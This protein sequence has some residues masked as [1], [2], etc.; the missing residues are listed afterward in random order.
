MGGAAGKRPC[1]K[2]P[3]MEFYLTAASARALTNA[4]E[5]LVRKWDTLARSLSLS[6]G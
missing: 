4:E 6:F 5:S 1:C 2:S 3:T